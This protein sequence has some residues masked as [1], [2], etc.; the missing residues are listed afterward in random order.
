MNEDPFRRSH[1]KISD[2]LAFCQQEHLG[3]KKVVRF[4]LFNIKY[5]QVFPF[6][7]KGAPTAPHRPAL[8]RISTHSSQKRFLTLCA[9][10]PFWQLG[11]TVDFL[12]ERKSL[13]MNKVSSITKKTNDTE[14]Q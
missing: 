13:E 3:I 10:D 14:M 6:Q 8:H 2:N 1:D 9:R 11:K 7:Y 12:S 4:S 5:H